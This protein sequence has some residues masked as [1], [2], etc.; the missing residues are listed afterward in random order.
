MST[1]DRYYRN[2]EIGR[3]TRCGKR[4]Q[5]ILDGYVVCEVCA[6][7][8]RDRQRITRQRREK[9]ARETRTCARCGAQDE[10]TLGGKLCCEKCL[11]FSREKDRLRKETRYMEPEVRK[12][13]REARRCLQL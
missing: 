5:R 13:R 2:I 1:L 7:K 3:C 6:E 8:D 9:R 4:D 11:K 12:E 10:R